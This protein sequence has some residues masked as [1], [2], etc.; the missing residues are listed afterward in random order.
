MT[1]AHT[2]RQVF[3]DVLSCATVDRGEET[4]WSVDKGGQLHGFHAHRSVD[5]VPS[6]MSSPSCISSYPT[7]NYDFLITSQCQIHKLSNTGHV[8]LSLLEVQA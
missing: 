7:G 1:W 5:S 2:Q 4:K 3:I 8:S 6:H